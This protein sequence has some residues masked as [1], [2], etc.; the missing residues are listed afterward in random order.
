MRGATS[1]FVP[2]FNQPKL[3]KPVKYRLLPIP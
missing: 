1:V 2:R 3:K